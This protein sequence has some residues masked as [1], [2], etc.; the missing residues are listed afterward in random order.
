MINIHL[1]CGKIIDNIPAK[2][3]YAIIT[4]KAFKHFRISDLLMNLII[5]YYLI[6][7]YSHP[8]S[9]KFNSI[10]FVH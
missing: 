9:E 3:L 10:D 7:H 5:I 1:T 4:N 8:L 2:Y 6:A